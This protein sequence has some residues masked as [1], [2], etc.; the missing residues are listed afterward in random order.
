MHHSSPKHHSGKSLK[1]TGHAK[2]KHARIPMRG[3]R[4]AKKMHGRGG[5]VRS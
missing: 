2:F 3:P 5:G 4:R 1:P